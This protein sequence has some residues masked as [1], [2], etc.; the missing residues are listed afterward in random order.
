MRAPVP[1]LPFDLKSTIRPLD[2]R[3]GD[4]TRKR[5]GLRVAGDMALPSKIPLKYRPLKH[6]ESNDTMLLYPFLA[7]SF[8]CGAPLMPMEDDRVPRSVRLQMRLSASSLL[9][10]DESL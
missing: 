1:Y 9:Q 5:K 8:T 10:E 4:T 6:H 2:H 3:R 7:S